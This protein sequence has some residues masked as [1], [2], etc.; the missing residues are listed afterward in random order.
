MEKI[1]TVI[2][3]RGLEEEQI[4]GCDFFQQQQQKKLVSVFLKIDYLSRT[5]THTL[6]SLPLSSTRSV[7]LTVHLN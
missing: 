6:C 4:K 2:S 3:T 1:P 5:N 7:I